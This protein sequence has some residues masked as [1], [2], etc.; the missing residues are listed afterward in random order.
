MRFKPFF[1]LVAFSLLASVTFS[2]NQMRCEHKVA[3]IFKAFNEKEIG[4]I[5]SMY[6]ND[7]TFSGKEGALAK[8][9]VSALLTQAATSVSN[10]QLISA[11]LN[12]TLELIYEVTYDKLGKKMAR[13][14]FNADE[15]LKEMELFKIEVK[16]LDAAPTIQLPDVNAIK[17]PFQKIGRLI[18]VEAV[19][20]GEKRLFIVDNGAPKLILNKH[21]FK[22]KDSTGQRIQADTPKGVNGSIQN[23]DIVQLETFDFYGVQLNHQPVLSIDLSHLEKELKTPIYGLIGYEVYK[24]FD[25]LFDYPN[26]T[27]TLLK[28]THSLTY[29]NENANSNAISVLPIELNAHL[30]CMKG[31]IGSTELYLA[32]DCGAESNLLSDSLFPIIKPHV[33][34][35]KMETL[36]GADNAA[37]LVKKGKV[38]RLQL[39]T[40]VFKKCN[41]TFSSITQLNAG[42]KIKL[43]GLIGFDILSKQ[44]TLL[45]YTNKQIWFIP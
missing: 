29:I 17:I 9:I 43:D 34:A 33:S 42:Y 15:A 45:S 7:F 37:R 26:Q 31:K 39:G 41:T 30:A 13:F 21:Y 12:N 1:L 35:I 16:T 4:L 44:K 11:K 38:N 6:A 19:V 8:R 24:T 5:E 22:S 20:N 10:Y 2:Q 27:L 18:G 36:I 25:L 23:L 3:L 40:L 32:I 28:P 14:V